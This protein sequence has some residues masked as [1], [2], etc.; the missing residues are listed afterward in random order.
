MPQ[1]LILRS[2]AATQALRDRAEGRSRN[3]IVSLRC[4][5]EGIVTTLGC[6]VDV[7]RQQFFLTVEGIDG[8]PGSPLAYPTGELRVPVVF[9]IP[10][11][12]LSNFE[13]P[14]V[15]VRREAITPDMKRWMPG[16]L[17]YRTPAYGAHEVVYGKG[18]SYEKRGYDKM[19]QMQMAVP[20]LINY[21]IS[22]LARNRGLAQRNQANRLFDHVLRIYQP[23]SMMKLLDSIGD[24]RTY[25]VQMESTAPLDS[26]P[27]VSERVIGFSFSL[28]VMAELD[29]A[30]TEVYYTLQSRTM[31]EV[32]FE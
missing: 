6:T 12:V 22:I 24:E 5:D 25:D 15:V 16:Q 3:G 14:L 1:A 8:P 9:S 11:D 21:T 32:L 31:R 28:S 20:F 19:E 10:E 26:I 7:A 13:N 2:E 18:K 4:F 17:Q 30:P 23:Y 27:E 29:L